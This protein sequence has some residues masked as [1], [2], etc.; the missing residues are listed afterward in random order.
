VSTSSYI[1]PDQ[2]FSPKRS[3]KLLA[4]LDSGSKNTGSVAIG[5]WEDKPV[6][7]MRWNGSDDNPLG[8]PQSRGLP[9]WFIIPD[10]YRDPIMA[11]LPADKQAFAKTFLGI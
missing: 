3:W 1:T 9:T 10:E 4:V 5:R 11:N 8:N 7:A 2:V 6:L